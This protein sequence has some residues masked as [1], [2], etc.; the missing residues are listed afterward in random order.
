MLPCLLEFCITLKSKCFH[1]GQISFSTFF[2]SNILRSL[3][4]SFF[5][6]FSFFSEI[7]KEICLFIHL[8][9]RPSFVHTHSCPPY[10]EDKSPVIVLLKTL[11]WL[12]SCQSLMPCTRALRLADCK[13]MRSNQPGLK[14]GL[15]SLSNWLLINFFDSKFW[16]LIESSL[17]N[18]LNTLRI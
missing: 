18:W 12:W 9:L 10:S 14:F 5:S 8:E 11:W 3:P 4:H 1:L 17:L 15:K 13:L 2:K 16:N 7:K 6:N